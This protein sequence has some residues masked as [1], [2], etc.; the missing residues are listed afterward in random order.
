[1]C[2]TF[3]IAYKPATKVDA[4]IRITQWLDDLYVS[5]LYIEGIGWF[6][7]LHFQPYQLRD[8]LLHLIHTEDILLIFEVGAGWSA[9]GLSEGQKYW[10]QRN[11]Y[12][13]LP[14]VG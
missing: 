4:S 8:N 5:F 6:A 10:L 2:R 14:Q 13:G 9:W 3:F 7:A 11:W 12:P 1:M